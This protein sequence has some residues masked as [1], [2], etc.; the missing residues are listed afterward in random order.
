MSQRDLCTYET[1]P[2]GNQSTLETAGIW[3]MLGG[4][5]VDESEGSVHM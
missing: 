4:H 5:V 3:R 2:T 1:K